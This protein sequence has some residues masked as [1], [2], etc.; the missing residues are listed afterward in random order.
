MIHDRIWWSDPKNVLIFAGQSNV[1]KSQFLQK[2]MSEAVLP[3]QF[4]GKDL[5]VIFL[6]TRTTVKPRRILDLMEEQMRQVDQRLPEVDIQRTSEKILTDKL[7][8]VRVYNWEQMNTFQALLEVT[9]KERRDTKRSVFILDCLSTFYWEHCVTVDMTSRLDFARKVFESFQEICQEFNCPF[10]A[11]FRLDE[12][13][14]LDVDRA[15][16]EVVREGQTISYRANLY[17]GESVKVLK[18]QITDKGIQWI[19]SR[20]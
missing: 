10:V 13:V 8:I 14:D 17:Q 5:N 2:M 3:E 18:Y 11:G 9:L 19:N 15:Y 4:K 16:L 20:K 1:G 6:S 12:N 7:M